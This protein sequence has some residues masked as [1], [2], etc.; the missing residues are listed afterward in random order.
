MYIKCTNVYACTIL[1]Y[2]YSE[3]KTCF[4]W[5]FCEVESNDIDSSLQVSCSHRYALVSMF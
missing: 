4:E 5:E 2:V 3:L 1:T